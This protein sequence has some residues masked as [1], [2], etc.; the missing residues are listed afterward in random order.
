MRKKKRDKKKRKTTP[1]RGLQDAVS[2][3]TT[4]SKV[5]IRKRKT[6]NKGETDEMAMRHDDCK[7]LVENGDERERHIGLFWW[8]LR[9]L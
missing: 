8:R 7:D 2:A 5:K 3:W 9:R 4:A 1:V 6:E